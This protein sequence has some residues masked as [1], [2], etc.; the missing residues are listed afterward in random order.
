MRKQI[1]V[2]LPPEYSYTRTRLEE[3]REWLKHENENEYDELGVKT[4]IE[5]EID[6]LESQFAGLLQQYEDDLVKLIASNSLESLYQ[7][8]NFLIADHTYV[9]EKAVETKLSEEFGVHV[10]G[11]MQIQATDYLMTFPSFFLI[12]RDDIPNTGELLIFLAQSYGQYQSDEDPLFESSISILGD[13][14]LNEFSLRYEQGVQGEEWEI[15]DSND[16]TVGYYADSYEALLFVFQEW[17]EIQKQSF[18]Q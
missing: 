17:D 5:D 18:E 1:R 13:S 14:A 3:L 11:F 9:V 7:E 6:I 8:K 4:V 16:F 15:V 12:S 10:K 2:P